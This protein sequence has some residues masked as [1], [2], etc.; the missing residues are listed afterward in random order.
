MNQGW[1]GNW[2]F[3][4][5]FSPG[6][7]PGA[8]IF[9]FLY[10]LGI[11][12]QFIEYSIDPGVSCCQTDRRF[13]LP[14]GYPSFARIFIGGSETLH[15]RAF[16]LITLGSGMGWLI[17]LIGRLTSDF[18]VAEAYGFLSMFSSPHFSFGLAILLSILV[19]LKKDNN[20]SRSLALSGLAFVESVIFLLG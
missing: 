3:Q 5:P 18:W 19:E 17:F 4:L 12:G 7:S 9:L 13:L 11:P 2:R 6:M 15:S 10:C 1:H 16:L 8:Y 14:L 20:W